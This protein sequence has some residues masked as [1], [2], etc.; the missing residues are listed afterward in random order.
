M[1][2]PKKRVREGTTDNMRPRRNFSESDQP[3]A[4]AAGKAAPTSGRGSWKRTV[5][6]RIIEGFSK[7]QGV[8]KKAG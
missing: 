3:R 6:S 7:G 2:I 8:Y 5:W 4:V 1:Q